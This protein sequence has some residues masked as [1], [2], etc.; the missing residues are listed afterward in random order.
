MLFRSINNPNSCICGQVLKDGWIGVQ[1][2]TPTWQADHGFLYGEDGDQWVA[3][4][5]ERFDSGLLSDLV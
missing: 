2:Q 4:I 1:Y 3:L 5:K